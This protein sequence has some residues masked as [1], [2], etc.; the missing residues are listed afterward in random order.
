MTTTRTTPVVP[1]LLNEGLLN[2]IVILVSLFL[3]SCS[4]SPATK[5]NATDEAQQYLEDA[6][7]ARKAGPL[8]GDVRVIDGVEY[9]YGRNVKYMSSSGEPLYVWVRRDLFSPSMGDTFPARAGSPNKAK[10]LTDLQQRLAKL[11]RAM[12]GESTPQAPSRPEQP[13]K[14][15]TGRIWTRYFANDDGL[16]WFLDEGAPLE[17]SR[18]VIQMWRKRVFP[19]WA[20]QKEIVTLDELD[21]HEARYR[22]RELRVTSWDG[23]TQ[24][25]D[26]V[27]PWANVFSSNPEEYLMNEYCK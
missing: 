2:L 26:N 3:V 17:A 11:E 6:I 9:V 4:H 12:R 27:T 24:T 23:K 18:D 8:D 14:D 19:S 25:S 13:V 10:D 22:I 16:E 20:F 1:S 21:C 15:A 7:K 5:K